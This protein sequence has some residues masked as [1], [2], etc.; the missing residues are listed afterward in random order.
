MV[1]MHILVVESLCQ[2]ATGRFLALVCL[3][4]GPRGSQW[5]CLVLSYINDRAGQG[6]S[7]LGHL[8]RIGGA[9]AIL[10]GVPGVCVEPGLK[11]IG[12]GPARGLV[13]V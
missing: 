4:L 6:S 1:F 7:H 10:H 11:G 12:T 8:P 3:V 13:L 2:T 9:R 5:L